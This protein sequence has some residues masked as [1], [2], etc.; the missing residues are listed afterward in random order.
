MI[1]HEGTKDTKGYFV[2]KPLIPNPFPR[3]QGKGSYSY[4]VFLMV[5]GLLI[6]SACT[7]SPA[8]SPTAI[9]T[10]LGFVVLN[11]APHE[12]ETDGNRAI[13][14]SVGEQITLEGFGA[15]I[16]VQGQIELEIL[17]ERLTVRLISGSAV[18]G[19][20]GRSRVLSLENPVEVPLLDGR[21]QAPVEVNEN[22]NTSTMLAEITPE[23]T[24]AEPTATFEGDCTL[25]EDWGRTY[26]V[27][28]GDVLEEIAE[29]YGLTIDEIAEANCLI[30]PSRL[31][32]GQVLRMPGD[33]P[34]ATPSA[35]AFRAD[36]YDLQEG[37]CTTLRW[38]VFNVAEVYL[39]GTETTL[40]SFLEVCPEETTT[41]TLRV[42]FLDG[43]E[44]ERE[45]IITVLED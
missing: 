31:R 13:I 22:A 38:D 41:Y 1:H 6:L 33:V 45:L 15:S 2:L 37:Q 27:Q 34:T 11:N 26:T 14:S 16:V 30:D 5:L 43:N 9:A 40:N 19:A 7:P 35:I 24:E 44:T 28:A 3:I 32:I 20:N 4:F 42:V 39:D 23:A 10:C 17:E 29:A 36:I 21:A 18:V 12:C 25:R 8:P